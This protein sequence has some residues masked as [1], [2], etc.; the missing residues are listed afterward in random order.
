MKEHERKNHERLRA[1]GLWPEAS[2]FREAERKR[3]GSDFAP[4]VAINNKLAMKVGQRC[5]SIT[6]QLNVTNR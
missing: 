1:E 6:S 2:E 4:S 3:S 5:W